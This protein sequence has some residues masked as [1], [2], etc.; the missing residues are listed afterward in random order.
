MTAPV[1]KIEKTLQTIHN[2]TARTAYRAIPK[3]GLELVDRYNDL[4]AQIVAVGG[5]KN[6]DW[7]A[8]CA[9]IGADPSHNGYDFFC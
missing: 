2:F 9:R 8:Y 4:K 1:Q 3:R 6:P 5:Y 7:Q